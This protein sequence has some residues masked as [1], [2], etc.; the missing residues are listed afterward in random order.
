MSRVRVYI[1]IS[2]VSVFPYQG[3]TNSKP[4][5]LMIL[6]CMFSFSFVSADCLHY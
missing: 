1:N 5:Q 6:V 4:L 3:Q 2:Q